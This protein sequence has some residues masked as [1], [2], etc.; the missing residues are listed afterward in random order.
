MITPERLKRLKELLRD[1]EMCPRLN[2]YEEEFCDSM[3]D[4]VARYGEDTNLSDAQERVL[5]S[6]EAKVYA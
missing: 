1:A 6:I 5:G 4:R 2:Q 3:R